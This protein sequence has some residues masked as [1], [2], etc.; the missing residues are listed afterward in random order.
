MAV[1]I[2]TYVTLL[3]QDLVRTGCVPKDDKLPSIL[4][5]VLYNGQKR[6]T[7][8][9]ELADLI[10]S[11]PV[12]LEPYQPGMRYLLIDEGCYSDGALSALEHNLVVALF[13]L[14]K[15]WPPQVL[16]EVLGVLIDWLRDPVQANLQ[17]AFTEWL[18]RV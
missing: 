16:L 15:G 6:W 3:Y 5:I 10:E 1:R 8:A 17:R 2:A 12:G 7:A 18:K 14:E 4:P 9:T 13:R 11:A